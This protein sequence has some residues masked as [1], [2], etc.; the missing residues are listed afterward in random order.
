MFSPNDR[1]IWSWSGWIAAAAMSWGAC[2]AQPGTVDAPNYTISSNL[3]LRAS[4]G[5]LGDIVP[6]PQQSRRAVRIA[7]G[8]DQLLRDCMEHPDVWSRDAWF[9]RFGHRAPFSAIGCRERSSPG[10]HV[11]FYRTPEGREAWAH[12][13][14]HGPQNIPLHLTEVVRNRLTFGRTSEYDVY[15]GLVRL[16]PNANGPN[17]HVR[18]NL[19]DHTRKYLLSAFGPQALGTGAAT[20]L[21]GTMFRDIA[22]AVPASGGYTNRMA[23][24]LTTNAIAK[25][26]EFGTAAFLQQEQEFTPSGERGFKKRAAYALYRTFMV[27]GRDGDELAFPRIAAAVGTGMIVE[28]WHPWQERQ[29][30]AWTQAGFILARCALKS[31]WTEFKPEILHATRK[32]L[33]RPAGDTVIGEPCP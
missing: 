3:Q 20:A 29:P 22:G 17:P 13:D 6:A 5:D 33:H 8:G 21:T 1:S 23:A 9:A 31:Y 30:N 28:R 16:D 2:H 18:Y 24:N 12:F 32:V 26:I 15:R 19:S 7:E 10:L 25:S 14:L 4:R 27:P 11:V